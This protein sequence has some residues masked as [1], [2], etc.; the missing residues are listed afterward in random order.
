MAIADNPIEKPI[1]DLL[2]RRHLAWDFADRVLAQNFSKGLV[3]VVYGPWG[4]GKTSYINMARHRLKLN[5]AVLLDFN[6]WMFSG[7]HQLVESFFFEVSAQLKVKGGNY[8]QIGDQVSEYGDALSAL[9]WIPVAGVWLERLRSLTKLGRHIG[10]LKGESMAARK[11]RIEGALSK[12]EHPLVVVIDDVDRLAPDE[13]RDVFKLIRLTASFPNVIYLLAFDRLLV[14]AALTT[15][16]SSGRAYLEKI[17]QFGS[18]LP[19][20]SPSRLAELCGQALAEATAELDWHDASDEDRWP[21]IFH[22]VVR[23][24]IR[25]LRDVRRYALSVEATAARIG[26]AV[27]VSDMFA[28]EAIRT[29]LP[30]T[31]ATFRELSGPLT[32]MKSGGWA[33]PEEDDTIAGQLMAVIDESQHPAVVKACLAHVFPATQTRLANHVF[34]EWQPKEWLVQGRVARSEVLSFYFEGAENDDLAAHREASELWLVLDDAT[35]LKKRLDALAGDGLRDVLIALDVF[36]EK[37]TPAQVVP[38]LS[39]IAN[40]YDRIP[41]DDRRFAPVRPSTILRI[42]ARSFIRV[43]EAAERPAAVA[44]ICLNVPGLTAQWLVLSAVCE[45]VAGDAA[46]IEGLAAEDLWTDWYNRI[47]GASAED[48]PKESGLVAITTKAQEIDSSFALPVDPETTLALLRSAHSVSTSAT[49]GSSKVTHHPRLSWSGFVKAVG[50]ETA[51]ATRVDAAAQGA[52]GEDVGL[53]ELATK[54]LSGWD[55]DAGW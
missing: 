51:A 20:A 19:E 25:N 9:V 14:E 37:F 8:Q 2:D 5:G 18:N 17:V 3:A 33:G 16:S 47:A 26:K 12:L 45:P 29:F 31:Y 11:A 6:P 54:Y 44:S 49:S 10:R 43:V 32:S 13:I 40:C 38:G 50:G 28:L 27:C 34:G 22:E 36:A 53:V 41:T 30:D 35:A 15:E 46:L 4:S 39:A 23:P 52:T 21:F 42:F 55:P 7:A 48:L 24:L 1:E